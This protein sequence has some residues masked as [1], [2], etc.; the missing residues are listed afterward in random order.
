MERRSGGKGSRRVSRCPAS[1]QVPELVRA[2]HAP[3]D[4]LL[5]QRRERAA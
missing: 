1:R 5:R 4:G 2:S 3:K